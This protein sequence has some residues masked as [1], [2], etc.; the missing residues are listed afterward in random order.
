MHIIRLRGPWQITPLNGVAPKSLET[1]VPGDWTSA[2]GSDYRGTAA[3]VRKFGLPTNLTNERVSLVVE[4]V[5]VLASL[6]LN[7]Q[8]LGNQSAADGQRKYDVTSLLK[9]RNELQIIVA[10]EAGGPA[11]GLGEVRLE[12]EEGTSG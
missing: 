1:E 3:Y 12:I 8:P 9:L 10:S 7:G 11:G 5:T 2:L 6:A 4:Q